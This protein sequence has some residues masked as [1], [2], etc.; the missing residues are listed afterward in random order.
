VSKLAPVSVDGL[1]F[2]WVYLKVPCWDQILFNVFI[3]DLLYAVA[4]CLVCNF[5]DDNTLY[6]CSHDINVILDNLCLDVEIVGKWLNFNGMV[7]NHDKFQL[8]IL[9]DEYGDLSIKIGETKI[10]P[11]K[12]VKLLG[13]ILDEKLSFYPHVKEMCKKVSSKTKALFRIRRF[14]DQRQSNLLYNAFILSHFQYCP[15]VWMFCSKEAHNLLC[16]THRRALAARYGLSHR[17]YSEIL[18]ETSSKPIH[19][20][21]LELL[22]TEVYKSINRLNPEIMWNLFEQKLSGYNLRRGSQML[23]PYGK[24]DIRINSF[25]FRAALAWNH[26]PAHVKSPKDVKEFRSSI[27]SVQIYCNCKLCAA[28]KFY[29]TR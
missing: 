21:H 15:L 19:R 16:A 3:N 11:K 26:L 6:S 14:L 12:Q 7:A 4:K 18:S 29:P 1:K 8:I 28:H 2:Y 9:G 24:K 13:V 17:T 20:L 27:D 22:V 5:A 23:I 10:A 25:T